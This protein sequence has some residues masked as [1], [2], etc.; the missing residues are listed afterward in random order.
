MS[1]HLLWPAEQIKNTTA[2]SSEVIAKLGARTK[3]VLPDGTQV[4]LNSGSKLNY[5]NDF[6]SKFR[7]VELDG[8]AFFDVVKDTKHP[9]IVHASS[10]NI[11]VVGTAFNVKSYQQDETI[12]TTLLRGIIEVSKKDNPTGPKVILRP[13]E[14]LIFN[15]LSV[16]TRPAVISEKK[17]SLQANATSDISI[18][19][20]AKNVPDSNKIETSWMYNKLIFDGDTFSELAEKMERWYNVKIIF[21][22]NELYH[23]RFKGVF[24]SETVQEAF[25]ALKLTANFKYKIINANEIELYKN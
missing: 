12:E 6:D 19:P 14:K 9:F 16:T 3:L 13:N 21:K 25:D 7:E 8:E 24:S 23:Y 20:I 22:S 1:Y 2:K 17:D 5:K 4:W 11:K 18:T 15:K 10:I